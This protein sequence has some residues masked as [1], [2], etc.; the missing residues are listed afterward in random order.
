MI[1]RMR[2]LAIATATALMPACT[3]NPLQSSSG[4]G[5]LSGVSVSV[6]PANASGA[7]Q[8]DAPDTTQNIMILGEPI[9]SAA[10][11]AAGT[12]SI[13]HGFDLSDHSGNEPEHFPQA[14]N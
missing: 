6:V 11:S 1:Y 8:Q 5:P 2:L 3:M 14:T 13:K 4:N 7:H 12:E 9:N 10:T